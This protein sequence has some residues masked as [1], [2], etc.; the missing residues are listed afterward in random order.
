MIQGTFYGNHIDMWNR[1]AA[2]NPQ[3]KFDLLRPIAA[4]GGQP[5]NW[6]SS[7]IW[8]KNYLGPGII[9][10]KKASPDRLKE[11]LRVW[12]WM[13]APFGSQ[14]RLLLEYGVKDIDYH[15]DEKGNPIPTPQGGPDATF[16]WGP[17]HFGAHSPDP[18]Y[19]APTPDYGPAMQA[20]EQVM[21][22]EGV[23][24]LTIG[25]YSTT[26]GTKGVAINQTFGSGVVDI[27][28]GRRPIGDL[29]QLVKDWVNNGGDQ[30]R[31]EYAQGIAA[32][33]H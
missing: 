15:L 23:P 24:D 3:V 17:M 16:A 20:D 32:Q 10:F 1:G 7:F 22:P 25:V 6:L 18:L 5:I 28:A 11:L 4:D 21:V 8:P 29:D 31:A 9:A 26:D 2:L 19:N 12:N 33:S 27:I 30:I 14:E 13:A